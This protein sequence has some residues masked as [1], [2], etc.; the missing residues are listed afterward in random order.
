MF[1]GVFMY[2]TVKIQNNIF[3]KSDFDRKKC[4]KYCFMHKKHKI[5][6]L[7]EQLYVSKTY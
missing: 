1:Q 4:S 6:R 3:N 2:I 5:I 7:N